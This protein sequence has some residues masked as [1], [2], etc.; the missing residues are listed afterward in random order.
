MQGTGTAKIISHGRENERVCAGAARISTTQGDADGIFSASDGHPGNRALIQKVLRSGHSSFIEHAVFTIAFSNVSVIVEQ[1]LIEFRL[2]SFTVKSRR[3]VDFGKMGYYMPEGMDAET[4]RVYTSN[5]DSLFAEYNSFIEKGVPKEDARFLLPYCFL[6]NFYLTVNAREL[7][8][9][10]REIYGGRGRRYF[11]LFRLAEQ[12]WGQL[13]ELFPYILED[14][15]GPR[16]DY[17][18][19]EAATFF[20]RISEAPAVVSPESELVEYSDGLAGPAIKEFLSSGQGKELGESHPRLLELISAAFII[21]DIS[22]AG[23]THVVRH[24]LQTIIIPPVWAVDPGRFLLPETVAADGELKERYMRAY[25]K[26]AQCV[27]RLRALGFRH[28]AYLALSGNTLDVVTA[29]NA[30]EMRLF[31]R[32]R[33]C[34]RAQW[35]VRG[36]ACGML[37]SLREKNADVFSGF[38]PSCF[39]DGVCPEGSLS[40]G[41][42]HRTF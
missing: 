2:A 9:M 31:F 32:L 30:R 41:R 1:F 13:E 18:G 36:I 38:G 35:E 34:E 14:L 24:R 7:R 23:I 19:E 16:S 27:N 11:E 12:L 39:A 4:E 42:I 17:R 15:K 26:N 21:R 28:E 29:M 33:C 3:Y 6:S 10:L 40:C 5:M 37:E 22:L 8:H 25:A 20:A